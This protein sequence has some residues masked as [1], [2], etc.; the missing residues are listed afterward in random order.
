[1]IV[2]FFSLLFFLIPLVF[3]KNTSE[4]F[5]FNKIITVYIFTISIITVCI[6]KRIITGKI[7]FRRTILD[8]PLIFYLSVLL[9]S[10]FFSI[11]FRT[12]WLGYYSRF[13]GGFVSSV[14][15]VLL[16]WAFVSNLK[17]T[18]IGRIINSI[19][20][21]IFIVSILAILEHFSF[22]ATC[23]LMGFGWTKSC[24]V[25]DVQNR[26]FSTM[27]QP[28]WL[29]ATMVALIPVSII[30][31]INKQSKSRVSKIFWFVVSVLLFTV[32]LFT[33]SRSGLLAFGIESL[34]FWGLIFWK[35]KFKFKNIFLALN[36]IF[37][38]LF[39]IYNPLPLNFKQQPVITT[40]PVLENGGTESGNIRKIVWKG[41]IDIWK[42]YP[43]LG[44][45]PE[46][47]AFAYP[48]VKTRENNLTSEWDFIYNKAH[49]EYLNYLATTGGLGFVAYMILI[50]FSTILIINYS[51]YFKRF[52]NKKD[53]NFSIG[54]S[55][56]QPDRLEIAILSG[57]VGILVSNFFGFSV[58]YTSV[59]FFIFP[60]ITFVEKIK[61]NKAKNI[62]GLK[63]NP[64]RRIGVFTVFLVSGFLLLSSVRYF[65]A[66][67]HF[68]KGKIANQNR[69]F[70]L[71]EKKLKRAINLNPKE[72]LF[73]SEYSITKAET[74]NKT[75]K[76]SI[77]FSEKAILLSPFNLNIKKNFVVV[78]TK[79][80]KFDQ[81]LLLRAIDVVNSSIDISPNDPGLYY[82]LGLLKIKINDEKNGIKSLIKAIELKENYKEARFILG[83]VYK[84]LKEN[85]LAKEQ[86]EYI[87]KN[88]D[89]KDQLTKKYLK[90]L[91]F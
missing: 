45:G 26:V 75:P 85:T 24:W 28:N 34:I 60:A 57:Y 30:E 18:D 62:K 53:A 89:P 63:M 2:Y 52:L 84:N 47:F 82:K 41:A 59:L 58:V 61:T 51:S 35:E 21:G 72:S 11:D 8:W 9:L 88:I 70:E 14:C 20:A 90:E 56:I 86:F 71:A 43:V 6:T 65:L 38:A 40:G 29:A 13:N 42:K 91:E 15:Y 22:F 76:E 50:L 80:S 79:L 4:V 81:K 25:Q 64:I 23:G 77:Y 49:N 36:L 17:S 16:Y 83:S 44:T 32:L 3:Y 5:E 67:I 78:L 68:N 10:T 12:S 33:K 74:E 87:L 37:L 69:D 54:R 66:D 73:L 27:G 55:I 31:L 39:M 46:T 7:I 19:F 48:L 1:M